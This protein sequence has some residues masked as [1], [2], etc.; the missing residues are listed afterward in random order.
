VERFEVEVKDLLTGETVKH[1]IPDYETLERID[2]G[3]V[4]ETNEVQ[5]RAKVRPGYV[6]AP[7]LSFV[8]AVSGSR[9]QPIPAG[10]V[11][12]ASGAD[13]DFWLEPANPRYLYALLHGVGCRLIASLLLGVRPRDEV[14]RLLFEKAVVDAR[15][16]LTSAWCSWSAC[17]IPA[18]YA[19][20][21]TAIRCRWR[22]SASGLRW[23]C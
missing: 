14:E 16:G 15:R 18:S 10:E 2:L 6:S 9:R 8:E 23:S 11:L 4:V 12:L 7:L 13:G 22:P 17:G 19:R 5:V 20:E 3:N 21:V 1:P